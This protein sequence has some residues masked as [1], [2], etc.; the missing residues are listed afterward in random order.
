[1]HLHVPFHPLEKQPWAHAV[2]FATLLLIL[3]GLVVALLV[4]PIHLD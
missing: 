3:L 1:M 4:G 2:D